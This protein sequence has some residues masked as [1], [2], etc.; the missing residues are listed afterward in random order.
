VP[1]AASKRKKRWKW[2]ATWSFA[3][4]RHFLIAL[5][6]LTTA[7]ALSLLEPYVWLGSVMHEL[8]FH[9][10]LCAALVAL[11]ALL[12]R[13]WLAASLLLL[14]TALFASPMLPLYRATRPTPQAGPLLRIATAHLAGST[15]GREQLSRWLTRERP[16]ALALTGVADGAELGT[17]LGGYRALRGN[18][19]LRALL[20]VQNALVVPGRER[21]GAHPTQAIRAGRCQARLVAVELPPLAVYTTLSARA[22]SIS[23]LTKMPSAPRSVWFGHFGSRADAHDLTAFSAHHSLRDG[24][25]GHGRSATAPGSLGPLGFPLSNVLVH[26][27]ISVREFEVSEPLVTGAHRTLRAT[28]ELTEARCRFTRAAELE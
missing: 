15:L 8:A 28:L 26:G 1:R 2:P 9:L 19:D 4:S 16:D 23:A 18:A 5:V 13:A 6:L 27:W 22:R 14:L 20:L 24:R 10:A 7:W 21:V 25:L 3:S 11:V 12:R 17:G